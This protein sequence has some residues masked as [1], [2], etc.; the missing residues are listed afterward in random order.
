VPPVICPAIVEY[1]RGFLSRTAD[2][3]ASLPTGSGIVVMLED[4]GALRNQVRACRGD[5]PKP[6]G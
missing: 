2:E 5:V 6:T 4:Y 1:D 3:V